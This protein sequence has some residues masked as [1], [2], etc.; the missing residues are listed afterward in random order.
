MHGDFSLAQIWISSGSRDEL[1]T[2]EA[3]WMVYPDKFG[4]NKTRLFIFYTLEN[5]WCLEYVDSMGRWAPSFSGFESSYLFLDALCAWMSM[6]MA[7]NMVNRTDGYAT[8]CYNLEC[9]GFVWVDPRVHLVGYWP[10]SLF[11]SLANGANRVDWGGEIFDSFGK[12]SLHTSTQMGSGHLPH[13]GFAKA[14]YISNLKYIDKNGTPRDPTALTKIVS[15]CGCYDID[16]HMRKDSH[17]GV[18]FFFGGQGL[19]STCVE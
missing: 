15:N 2:I 8:G 13:E 5:H 4:D 11:N 14:S 6:W 19:S 9:N 17:F 18:Y 12:G 10:N 16:V 1:N 7:G 3:G